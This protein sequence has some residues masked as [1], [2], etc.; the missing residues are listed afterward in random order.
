[1]FHTSCIVAGGCGSRGPVAQEEAGESKVS[2]GASSPHL[3][4]EPR[5]FSAAS[6]L[7]LLSPHRW[8]RPVLP[9]PGS[10]CSV[11]TEPGQEHHAS[12]QIGAAPHQ[13]TNP[14]GTRLWG[15]CQGNGAVKPDGVECRGQS[16]SKL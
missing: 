5:P 12:E 6:L 8:D 4:G 9:S 13:P 16:L 11:D 14:G 10:S 1:M 2:P 3:W 15:E 7:G